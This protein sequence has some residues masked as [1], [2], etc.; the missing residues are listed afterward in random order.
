M[1]W[2]NEKVKSHSTYTATKI[3]SALDI[4]Y[5]PFALVVIKTLALARNEKFSVH[6]FGKAIEIFF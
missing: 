6:V 4:L 3:V 2:Y 1:N 5:P